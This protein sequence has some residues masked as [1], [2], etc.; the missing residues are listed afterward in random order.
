[1]KGQLI[2]GFALI[3]FGVASCQQGEV[4]KSDF[5]TQKDSVSYTIGISVGKSLKKDAI[6]ISPDFLI[7]GI[8]D[9][10]AKDSSYYL[11]DAEMQKVMM[12]LQTQMM[13]KQMEKMKADGDV[14][15]KAG[16][17]F[18][19]KNKS[20]KGVIV[21]PSGLQYR[22]LQSG[23]GAQPKAT[24]KVKCHYKG[25]LINGNEFDSSIKRG[26][27]A[28]FAVNGV[29]KGWTEALQLMHVGDKWQLFIPPQ[30]GYG[31]QGAGQG[32][33]PPQATLIFEVELLGIEK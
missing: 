1:M 6:E 10:I 32:Q 29:I 33:I 27:P 2:L 15:K 14:N 7:Q 31:E 21:L 23:T 24:D 3:C 19:E 13:K 4:K 9:A 20:E 22:V 17:E 25:T 5:K 28:T 18:L 12:N 16:D 11:S 26:E 30:L 8:N